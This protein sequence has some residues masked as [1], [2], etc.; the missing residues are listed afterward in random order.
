MFDKKELPAESKKQSTPSSLFSPLTDLRR[1]IDTVFDRFWGPDSFSGFH[2]P[3]RLKVFD[4]SPKVDV[5]EAKD[6]YEITAEL[7]GVV[8]K[9]VEVSV[10]DGVLSIKGEKKSETKKEDKNAHIIERSYGSFERSFMLPDDADES[11]IN[12]DFHNGV[13]K[14]CIKKSEK[15]ASTTR[16][17][18]V[19]ST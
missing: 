17:I 8:E 9:D 2:F 16:K 4:L 14:V 7:P 15:A 11:K 18:E 10:K 19:K 6:A 1:E 12:A 3:A 13:L 5:V